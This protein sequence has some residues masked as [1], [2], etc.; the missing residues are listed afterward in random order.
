MSAHWLELGVTSVGLACLLGLAFWLRWRYVQQVSLHVDEFTTLWA[1]R[2]IL[3]K[4]A[5][6]MPSGVLYTRGLLN[7]YLI[8]GV[9]WFSGLTELAGRLPSVIFGLL[10]VLLT[11]W[12]GRRAWEPRVGWLAA[13][14]LVLL[15]E[16]IQADG[17]ARF[18]AQLLFFVL[19]TLWS[20]YHALRP[21][22]T[23]HANDQAEERA[24]WRPH[25]LFALCFGLALFSQEETILLYPPLLLAL[26]LWRGWRYLWQGPVLLS[27]GLC[28]A[29]M[30]LRFVI[31]QVGQPGYFASI[32]SHKSYL[33]LYFTVGAAWQEFSPLYAEPRRILW[34]LFGLLAIVVTLVAL[35]RVRW[36]P[37]LLFPAQQATLF[38]A[39]PFVFIF[40]AMLT[41]VGD[42]WRAARHVLLI[43]PCWLLV[44]AAGAVWLVD[45]FFTGVALRWGATALVAVA[46]AAPMWPLAQNMLV[47]SIEGYDAGFAYVQ[48]QRQPGDVTMT[49]QP[50]ACAAV[51]GEPCTYYARERGYEPYVT[52]QNGVVVDRWSG[53]QLLDS[54]AQ[55]QQVIQ[56]APR[57]WFVTDGYRLA[58][59]YN[60]D[61]VQLV[62]DQFDLVF[63]ER[64]VRV[65]LAQGWRPPPD[66]TVHKTFA[67]PLAIGAMTIEEWLR[68][69]A[70]PGNALNVELFWGRT[71]YIGEQVNTSVQIVAADGARLTQAD[72]PPALGMVSTFDGARGA[73]PDPKTVLLPADLAP[74]RYRVEVIA[75]D[76]ATR[77]PLA[78]PIAVDWFR[79]GPP[80]AP[81]AVTVGATWQ[82]GLTLVGHDELPAALTPEQTLTLR[83]VWQTTTPVTTDYT[84]FVHLLD[85]TGQIIAQSDR[86]P[87]GNFYPTS[88]W[89]IGDWA[90][91][92]TVLQLPAML[93][94]GRYRLLLGWYDPQTGARLQLPTGADVLELA[95]WSVVQ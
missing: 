29:F 12:I 6:L 87:E 67:P 82:N 38:F 44:G 78:D 36:R 81:P 69:T 24:A 23:Q 1:V 22:P 65:L 92:D 91:G 73:L 50:P 26:L 41:I 93:P 74:G 15:P 55:L 5:P 39:L 71:G 3:E 27:Q 8:A 62:V 88:G 48:A 30:A 37:L 47:N 51:L 7:S 40:G 79:I 49:P 28:I 20:A 95:Q 59:R 56:R 68:T 35:A 45:R 89:P 9:A 18:Y 58:K 72:G 60:S 52:V 14:G 54:S 4:G 63:E 19:L 84:L 11:W 86:A 42:E 75:Y 83:T 64:G 80:P 16:A 61:F 25:L 17:R 94:A 57:V 13:L 46:L 70:T 21:Q 66:Y 2:K 34:G 43:Q 77:E 90:M 33:G 31:E 10:S 53:A 32:Q 76:V 85:P